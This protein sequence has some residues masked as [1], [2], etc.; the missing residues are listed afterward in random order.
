[1]M[2]HEKSAQQAAAAQK[3]LLDACHQAT[4][5]WLDRMQSEMALWANL[6]PKL[7]TTPLAPG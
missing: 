5:H 2:E 3:E 4:H 6:G 1:M 7:A